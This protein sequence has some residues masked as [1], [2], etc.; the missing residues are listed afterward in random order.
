MNKNIIPRSSKP[1]LKTLTE[2]GLVL[3]RLAPEVLQVNV[4][5]YCNQACLHCHVEAGPKRKEKM[6]LEDASRVIEL[7]EATPSIHTLDITGGAP[8]LHPVF[9]YFVKKLIV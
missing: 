3:T 6:N 1:F 9:R 5:R 8:E 7:I 2:E 4:G